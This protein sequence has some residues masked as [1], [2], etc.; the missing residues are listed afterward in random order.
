MAMRSMANANISFGLVS[1]PV[2]MFAATESHDVKFHQYHEHEG[3]APGRI[4]QLRTCEDCGAV[5]EYGEIAKGV[6][7]GDD[8]IIVTADELSG[9]E[10]ES[11]K[12]F[13]VLLFCDSDQVDPIVFGSPYYLEPNAKQAKTALEAYAVLRTVLEE[14]GLVAIVQYTMRGKTHLGV[15]RVV[16]KVITLQNI[17]WHDE[18][19]QPE[20][21][22][23]D[24]DIA[25]KPELLKLAGQLVES[26]TGEFK[27]EEYTDE[28]TERVRELVEAKAAGREIEHEEPEAV[29]E[30][31]D[32]LAALERSI[33]KHPAG[34]GR[35][36]AVAKRPTKKS[37]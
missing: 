28:Y 35:G 16:G 25:V 20:F 10:V 7:R 19:R 24:R 22:S 15:L 26:M 12:D 1:V 9:I 14:S 4:K 27:A 18:L 11:G 5:V 36:K 8:V 13:D 37:A 21:S 6:E 2:K 30:V 23:L 34:K 31:S 3:E 17:V 29:E 32:L 33:A